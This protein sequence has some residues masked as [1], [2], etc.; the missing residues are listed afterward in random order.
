METQMHH[1]GRA[2]APAERLGK[3]RRDAFRSGRRGFSLIELMVVMGVIMTMAA[4]AGPALTSLSGARSLG[5]ASSDLAGLLELSRTFAMTNRTYVR[6]GIGRKASGE[7]AVYSIY[8]ANGLPE[9]DMQD[10]SLWPAVKKVLILANIEINDDLNVG[11][12][13]NE[14]GGDQ[15]PSDSDIG[16]F[17]RRT[18]KTD[19]AFA[20]IIQFSPYGEAQVQM[21]KT[22]R[23]IK[24]GMNRTNDAQLS[25]PL[26][27]RLSGTTGLIRFFHKEDGI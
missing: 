25:N 14:T 3:I 15:V 11:G 4:L 12:G 9:G 22:A 10:L 7:M 24:I 16:Q 27:V 8:A 26:I 5:G 21:G 23:Y 20:S 19:T 18:G 2:L 13:G 17:R 6:V 1:P